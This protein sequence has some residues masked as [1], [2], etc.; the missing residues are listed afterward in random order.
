M[1]N[2][3][4]KS[5]ND[6]QTP[7]YIVNEQELENNIKEFHTALNKYFKSAILGYSIKTNSLPYV[8]SIA[9][10]LNCYAEVVS[11]DE[12]N[13]AKSI[14]F[15]CDKIIYNGPMK[16]KDTFMEALL[17]GAIV[18]IENFREI[19]WLTSIPRNDCYNIG[20]RVNINFEHLGLNGENHA[21]SRFGF[22]YENGDLEK[23]I[24]LIDK[25]GLTINGIHA[26][27][28][29]STRGLN[30]YH[31]ICEYIS[32]IINKLKI[33]INYFDIGGG[34]FGKMPKQPDYNQYVQTIKESLHIDN[35][36]L[37]LIV[38]PGNGIIASPI[39]Y[40]LTILDC[41]NIENKVICSTNG[42]RLDID[43]FFHKQT[44]WYEH[45]K[46]DNARTTVSNQILAG[47]TCL[48]NDIL[49]ELNDYSCIAPG[50]KFLFKCVGAYTMAL[51]PNFINYLPIVYSKRN[52]VYSIIREKW[53]TKNIL[54]RNYIANNT[55]KKES[56]LFTNVG[57]R[58]KLMKDFIESIGDEIQII[59]SDN[60]SVAPALFTAQKYY[61]TPKIRDDNYINVLLDICQKENVKAITSLIDPEIQ[62]LAKNID[63]FKEIGVIP[64]CPSED[65]AELCFDKYKMFLHLRKTG[66]KTV[67][68]YNSLMEFEQAFNRNEIQFPVFIKPRTGSGSIGAAKVN[69][70]KE[71]EMAFSENKFDYI[72]Q[73]FMDCEDC[74]ADIYVDTITHKLVSA[75]LKKK[76]ETRIGGA[77]KTISFKDDKLFSFINQIVN[78][79]EFS[80]VVDMDF[81]IKNGEYYLNE[82]NPRIGGAYLHAYGA[83]VDFPKMIRNNIKGIK[84]VPCIGNYKEGII[85][86]MYDDVVITNIESLKGDYRNAK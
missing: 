38:E 78:E 18:N 65:S 58:G 3:Y 50:D 79:F 82:I 48:E 71:L 14:G 11:A 41:K 23:A 33:K 31:N 62:L 46:T 36:N 43:P 15:P 83:D 64:L 25:L 2:I 1:K 73:E 49:I 40:A 6:L 57:R 66:I 8:A 12:F 75:F 45:I 74:D 80:G 67:L 52:G 68:T 44:Y 37:T 17:N 84:N 56:I 86:L 85:M 27:R 10:N 24:N 16:T 34:F 5:I 61:L 70:M 42:S 63:R 32:Q 54:Q 76:I 39:D 26:H 29:S 69:T 35:D 21:F 4:Y 72:I 30:V 81:F 7:C 13:F 19:Q 53:T 59:A 55:P 9:K 20:I 47:S 22:S 51:T 28:T 60:W 77:S